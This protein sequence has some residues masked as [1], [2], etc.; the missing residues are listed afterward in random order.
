MSTRAERH[1]CTT[2]LA[3]ELAALGARLR[4]IH[5]VTGMPPRDIQR[6]FFPDQRHAPRG[7]VPDST[8]WYHRANLVLR[9]DA[10]IFAASYRRLRSQGLDAS[11]ALIAAYQTYRSITPAPTRIGIDRALNLASQL[12]GIWLARQPSLSAVVCAQCG[13]H[14][15]GPLGAADD[16]HAASRDCPF[17]KLLSRFA[18]DPRLQS[19]YPARPILAHRFVEPGSPTLVPR[20]CSGQS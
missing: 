3:Q 8:D 19:A 16:D 4:T 1:L 5:V 20:P 11:P 10:C 9:V 7:R 12:D 18:L 17:C 2:R 13:C 6:L 15:L 14:I